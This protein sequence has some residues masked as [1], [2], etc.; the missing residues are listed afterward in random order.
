[1]KRRLKSPSSYVRVELRENSLPIDIDKWNDSKLIFI[2]DNFD[3]DN[4]VKQRAILAAQIEKMKAGKQ[5]PVRF[6]RSVTYDAANPMGVMLRGY[7]TCTFESADGTESD[8]RP[9]TVNLITLDN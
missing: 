5:R 7:F 8:A 2:R 9:L 6:L 4:A 3:A 1:M